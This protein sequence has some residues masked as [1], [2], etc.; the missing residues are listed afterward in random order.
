MNA[1]P[2]P[3][4]GGA[5]APVKSEPVS[6]AS[7]QPVQ[8]AASQPN[9]TPKQQADT[10]QPMDTSDGSSNTS[11]QAKPDPATATPASVSSSAAS[12]SAAAS[13]SSASSS[14][15]SAPS[16]SPTPSAGGTATTSEDRGRDDYAKTEEDR[17]IISFPVIYNDGKPDHMIAL[18]GLKN[19]FSAQLPKMPK[20]YIVRL[21]LD[22]N[23]RSMC[24]MKKGRVIGGIC[25]RP[26][27][28]QAFAEIVFCAITS[29]EQVKGY[30]TR[31]MNQLKEHVKTEKIHYFLTYADN[32][33]IGYFKKQGFTK[34]ISQPRERWAGFIKDYDGGTLMECKINHHIDY[35]RLGA[36]IKRQRAAVHEQIKLI[37]NSHIIYP[38]LK[39]FKEL[40]AK[41]EAKTEQKDGDDAMQTG[42]GGEA[43]KH[44]STTAVADTARMS[45][46]TLPPPL[47]AIPDI[48]GVLEAGWAP[49]RPGSTTGTGGLGAPT[50]RT[51]LGSL[52]MSDLHAKLGAILKQLRASKDAWPFQQPVDAKVVPDYYTVIHRPMDLET[53]GKKLNAFEYKTKETF[54]EDVKLMVKNCM[55]YNTPE[56][57]YYRC[58]LS[59]DALAEKLIKQQFGSA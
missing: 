38:G 3:S 59:I 33:A 36:L 55:T 18:I 23:H 37:S 26:F 10:P 2:S 11:T 16:T 39:V 43:S 25:F 7:P 32:Y 49:P 17:G 22:R 35:L 27:L 5:V 6:A 51:S 52:G 29:T 28:S 20:E 30:G 44:D 45:S 42:E 19:I 53:M 50:T 14:S 21:V 34:Q 40:A 24:I 15:S 8:S 4:S 48:P 13:S 54:I 31:L 57:T 1:S 56:T 9:Q 41:T 46:S 58:A 12:S 47:I